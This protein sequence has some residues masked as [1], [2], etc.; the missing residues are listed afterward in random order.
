MG[1]TAPRP[2]RPSPQA[3]PG[4]TGE[5]TRSIRRSISSRK[6]LSPHTAVQLRPS[7]NSKRP[8]VDIPK[9]R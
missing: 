3:G 6:G 9:L 4:Q 2:V 7:S 5:T 1:I 8:G